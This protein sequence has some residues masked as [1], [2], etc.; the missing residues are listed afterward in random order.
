MAERQKLIAVCLSEAHSFLNTGFLTELGSAAA[1]CGYGIAVFNSSLDFYW[2]QKDNN[3]PRAGYRSIRYALFDA[4]F[5][6]CHSFHDDALVQE[7]VRGAQAH[8]VPVILS[9]G[10][11]PGCYS[12]ANDYENCFKDLIRHVIRDHGARDT[13]FIAGMKNEPN[14]EDRFRCYR[15]VLDESGIPFDPLRFAYGNYWAKPAAEITLSLI[16]SGKKLPDAIFCANDTMAIS[17]CD[18][19]RDN[20]FRV[21]E[22]VIVTGFDGVPAAYM[23]HPRLTTCSDNPRGLA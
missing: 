12:V 18:T 13:F 5:I 2:Y 14:S 15:E 7:I 21:P 23:F 9:G 6:I 16:R 8:G 22:D 17:V 10:S 20:G 4:V 19:L 1:A 3:A 11:M